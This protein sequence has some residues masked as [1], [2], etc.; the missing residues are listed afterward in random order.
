MIT[1]ESFTFDGAILP[2]GYYNFLLESNTGADLQMGH[3][4][5]Y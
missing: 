3:L 5:R 2:A 1:G 4:L